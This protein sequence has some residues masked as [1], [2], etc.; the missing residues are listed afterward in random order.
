MN[1]IFNDLVVS[2]LFFQTLKTTGRTLVLDHVSKDDAEG[3]YTC[4][5]TAF[6]H[7]QRISKSARMEVTRKFSFHLFYSYKLY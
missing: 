7:F 2:L 6:P 4:E 1:S 5:V 3:T